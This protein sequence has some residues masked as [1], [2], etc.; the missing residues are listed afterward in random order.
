MLDLQELTSRPG[1]VPLNNGPF[2]QSR[3]DKRMEESKAA[4]LEILERGYN[5]WIVTLS[6]GKD[7]TA[8][9][10]LALETARRHAPKRVKR[11]DVVY[12]DTMV[13][14]PTIRLFAKSMLSHIR[15]S[16]RLERL[17]LFTHIVRPKLRDRY[18]VRTLGAGYPPPHQQFRWCTRRLKI[19]PV[20]GRLARFMQNGNSVVLTGV[21]F[22]ES[23]TRDARLAASCSRGG[24]CGQGVWFQHSDR[25]NAGYLAPIISWQE[26]D[27]W[28]YVLFVA[29]ALGYPTQEL[30]EIYGSRDTRFG[31]WNCTVVRQER[32]LQQTVSKSRW[33]HLVP[34]ADFRKH[35]WDSTRS[36]GTRLLRHDGNPG[37][38]R[39]R[40]RESL[41]NRLL[42]VQE[43]VGLQLITDAELR[44]IRQL[45]REERER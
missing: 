37:K 20:E 26:C 17:P 3:L 9:T 13:E 36:H 1:P 8:T 7:S 11:I 39:I 18:W 24:E 30:E 27:V 23:A 25:L 33:Q 41:L 43:K 44:L 19:E 29:P 34:L 6:G 22:G 12:S 31:C 4:L 15:E 10:V 45:W 2:D 35:L 16:A 28:D 40:T 32:A 42:A 21:R 5:H 14:I 38:L